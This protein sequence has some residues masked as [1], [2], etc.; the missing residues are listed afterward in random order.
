MCVY[1]AHLGFNAFCQYQLSLMLEMS[2]MGRLHPQ[3][4]TQVQ[5]HLGAINLNLYENAI[6]LS[7]SVASDA[8]ECVHYMMRTTVWKSQAF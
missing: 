2:P 5:F 6:T 7:V 3:N 8:S 1:L 4:Q